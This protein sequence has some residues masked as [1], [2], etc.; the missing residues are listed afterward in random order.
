[1]KDIEKIF[2]KERERLAENMLVSFGVVPWVLAEAEMT[3]NIPSPKN[4]SAFMV[5]SLFIFNL[6]FNLFT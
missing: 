2:R 1:M 6:L 5:L 4:S 3:V